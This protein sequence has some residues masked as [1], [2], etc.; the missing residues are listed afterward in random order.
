MCYGSSGAALFG[1]RRVFRANTHGI[2]ARGITWQ[3]RFEAHITW[4]M[5]AVIIDIPEAR[6][7][8][9]A[10]CAPPDV[11][12]ISPVAAIVLAVEVERV[13]MLATPVK[14]DLPDNMELRQGSVAQG[15]PPNFR[16]L[17]SQRPTEPA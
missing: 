8:M 17:S 10:T 5:G 4:P 6:I 14:D 12:S 3:D 1:R 2:K 13:E 11:S 15:L 7:A 16:T 9:E